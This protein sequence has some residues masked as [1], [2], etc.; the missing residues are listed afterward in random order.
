MKKLV[1]SYDT[2]FGLDFFIERAPERVSGFKPANSDFGGK[3]FCDLRTEGFAALLRVGF[4]KQ[5]V[6][7]GTNE[8][9][10]GLRSINRGWATREML[11]HDLDADP[12]R[13]SVLQSEWAT[14]GNAKAIANYLV[15][16]TGKCAIVS[17][18]FHLPR[19]SILLATAGVQLPLY[20]AEIFLLVENTNRKQEI[21][22]R[23]GGS[24][25]AERVGNELEGV[26]HILLGT[27]KPRR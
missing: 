15:K 22:E 17:N 18:H 10:P 6:L 20:P 19:A 25:L 14:S 2:V 1:I 26:A 23:L 5:L 4:A 16:P 12:K 9:K 3:L 8:V 24:P 21:V 7:T 13:I 11:I 27:Y